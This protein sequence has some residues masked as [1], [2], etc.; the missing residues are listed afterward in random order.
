MIFKFE[1]QEDIEYD[2]IRI[3][4]R[5]D[6]G[7]PSYVISK[8]DLPPDTRSF[9][10]SYHREKNLYAYVLV[11]S[12]VVIFTSSFRSLEI[13]ESKFVDLS[14]LFHEEELKI[15]PIRD[16][17]LAVIIHQDLN[18]NTWL[19]TSRSWL[20]RAKDDKF[21][22]NDKMLFPATQENL[23][24][25]ADLSFK[26]IYILPTQLYDFFQY[27]SLQVEKA[28]MTYNKTIPKKFTIQELLM[29]IYAALGRFNSIQPQTRFNFMFGKTLNL[30]AVPTRDKHFIIRLAVIEALQALVQFW[31]DLDFSYSDGVDVEMAKKDAYQSFRSELNDWQ[32]EAA[33]I[34]SAYLGRGTFIGQASGRFAA[35]HSS[36]G[37][38]RPT[39]ESAPWLV[40]IQTVDNARQGLFVRQQSPNFWMQFR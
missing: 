28:E 35:P 12:G 31:I 7:S 13:E 25:Y 27:M 22:I 14:K 1:V 3:C 9:N 32:D 6:E 4:K 37:A 11:K 8:D 10:D 19:E 39:L 23:V 26:D 20:A 5:D 15:C 29:C 33:E 24:N 16:D 2:A 36:G 21:I 17:T 38:I 18:P 34:K 30:E 40:N